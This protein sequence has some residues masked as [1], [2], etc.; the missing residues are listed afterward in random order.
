MPTQSSCDDAN[1]LADTLEFNQLVDI[2][3]HTAHH[4]NSS[5]HTALKRQLYVP[6]IVRVILDKLDLH[7]A[8]QPAANSPLVGSNS[9][10]L[11]FCQ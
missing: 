3:L 8:T 1:S 9:W 6:H 7:Y 5:R 11:V 2:S 4:A 10:R